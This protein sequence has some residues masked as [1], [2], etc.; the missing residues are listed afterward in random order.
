MPE[1]IVAALFGLLIGSFL[2]VCIYRMPRDLSVVHPRSFCPGCEKPIAWYDNIP[3]LTWLLLRGACRHCSAPIS[4][5][6]PAVELLTGVLFFVGV[7]ELGPTLPAL[8][9]CLFAAIQVALIFTDVEERILPDEFTLGGTVVGLVLAWFVPMP[10]GMAGLL[11]DPDLD[12]RLVAVV[13]SAFGGLFLAGVLW[14]IGALYHRVRGREGLGLGDVKMVACIG[15]FLGLGNALLTVVAGS[16]LGSVVGIAYIWFAGEKA[17]EY[18]LPF[19]SFLGV[20]A[21]G[22]ALWALPLG[23]WLGAT[24]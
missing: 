18:E 19:G 4:W 13:E 5:R 21:I 9:F 10:P 15:A 23:H 3:V 2:N 20:A 7:Y 22:V 11:L 12:R 6:Y 24:L 1:A 16:V 17:S 14:S 8:K